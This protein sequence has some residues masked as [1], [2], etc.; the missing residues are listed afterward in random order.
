VRGAW[1][2]A[3]LTRPEGLAIRGFQLLVAQED[4]RI[5]VLQR[6]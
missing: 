3:G 2:I 1:T 6:P 5:A 4:G